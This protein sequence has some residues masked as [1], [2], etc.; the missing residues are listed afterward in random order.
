MGQLEL[1]QGAIQGF[2]HRAVEKALY[3]LL[4]ELELSARYAK[5][6]VVLYK[7]HVTHAGGLDK[8]SALSKKAY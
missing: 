4:S 7:T 6:E 8:S 2:V 3:F 1:S 5:G